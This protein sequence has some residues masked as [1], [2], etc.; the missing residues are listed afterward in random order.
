MNAASILTLTGS[1]NGMKSMSD[2]EVF[3]NHLTRAY[4]ERE[5]TEAEKQLVY[6]GWWLHKVHARRQIEK[7]EQTVAQQAEKLELLLE[8]AR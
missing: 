8:Q 5:F 2:K 3:D 7:L 1:A 6:Q 4:P